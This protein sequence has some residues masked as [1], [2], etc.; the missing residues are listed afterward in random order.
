MRYYEH[1]FV[2]LACQC[3]A[4]VCCRCSPTQ[5]AQI[6]KLLQQHTA[7]RTCAIGERRLWACE[8]LAPIIM[9]TDLYMKTSQQI[10]P[11]NESFTEMSYL[12]SVRLT[13]RLLNKVL[14]VC[15]NTIQ[16][17]THSNM[18][19]TSFVHKVAAKAK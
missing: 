8:V 19:F 3:P 18:C 13:L 6:V 2:E 14:Q 7:N 9:F 17:E 12:T 4:V 11:H 5:K 15:S 16:T 1:E 10:R